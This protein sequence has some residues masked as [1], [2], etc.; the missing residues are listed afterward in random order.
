MG[1]YQTVKNTIKKLEEKQKETDMRQ[2]CGVITREDYE[3]LEHVISPSGGN[4]RKVGFLVM[5]R[6]LT[7]A[8]WIEKYGEQ[9]L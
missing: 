1:S 8:E 3:K 5:T 4:S 2:H 6:K 9:M 7:E